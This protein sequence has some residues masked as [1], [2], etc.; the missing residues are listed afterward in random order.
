[1]QDQRLNGTDVGGIAVK[2]TRGKRRYTCMECGKFTF[3]SK[4]EEDRAAKLRC[5]GCGSGRLE[6]SKAGNDRMVD[7]QDAIRD[8]KKNERR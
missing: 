7:A 8:R 4:R 2:N 1:M 5:T 3:F 6:V